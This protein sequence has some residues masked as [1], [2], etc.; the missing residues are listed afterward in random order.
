MPLHDTHTKMPSP[1]CKITSWKFSAL[2]NYISLK[3]LYL[4]MLA[5]IETFIG[6]KQAHDY[7]YQSYAE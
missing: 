6:F 2:F 7:D 5:Y 3:W 1:T 4:N